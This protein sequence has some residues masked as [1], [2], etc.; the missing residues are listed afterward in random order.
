MSLSCLRI[1][2]FCPAWYSV[3][4]RSGCW[5]WSRCR[6]GREPTLCWRCD[7]LGAACSGTERL[8]PKDERGGPAASTDAGV[9]SARRSGPAAVDAGRDGRPDLT[10]SPPNSGVVRAQSAASLVRRL[11]AHEWQAEP[12]LVDDR[13]A[14]R[15]ED[16]PRAFGSPL[17]GSSGVHEAAAEPCPP[18]TRRLRRACRPRTHRSGRAGS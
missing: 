8:A 5:G 18:R 16:S 11:S 14:K 2:V 13:A 3:P 17:P 12:A 4:L 10:N 1:K 7:P 6:R 9:L 15:I